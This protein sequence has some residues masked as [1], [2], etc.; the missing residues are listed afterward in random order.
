M[1]GWVAKQTNNK[2]KKQWSSWQRVFLKNFSKNRI[3]IK[4]YCLEIT[5]STKLC[6]KWLHDDCWGWMTKFKHKNTTQKC[7]W[8]LQKWLSQKSNCSKHNQV[9]FSQCTVYS[10][11]SHS[12]K[13][14]SLMLLGA[15]WGRGKVGAG[16]LNK[17]EVFV[18]WRGRE[19][20]I[21]VCLQKCSQQHWLQK[22]CPSSSA[23][24]RHHLG[25]L[26]CANE[27]V[28]ASPT[29]PSRLRRPVHKD[30]SPQQ[31]NAM[32]SLPWFYFPLVTQE[33]GQSAPEIWTTGARR[34]TPSTAAQAVI[35]VDP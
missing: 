29:L 26:V 12:D 19:M 5:V 30:S 2:Q 31:C 4:L 35:F 25:F 24:A 23:A 1:G 27:S 10:A 9:K 20:E 22:P 28:N 17:D 11:F 14:T 3:N 8:F 13:N 21:S 34:E 7:G 33:C 32:A 6:T 18:K 16:M 15:P